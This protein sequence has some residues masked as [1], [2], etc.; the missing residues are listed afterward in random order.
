MSLNSTKM[1][2][3]AAL[4]MA[5]LTLTATAQITYPFNPDENADAYIGAQDLMQFLVVFGLEWEQ[6]EL[7]VDSIP[8]SMYLSSL[9][10]MIEA[11]ALPEGTMPGQFL[12]WTGE[13]WEL[14][15]PKVGCTLPE[16]CNYD[17][18]A[19]V[20]LESMCVLP[21]ACGV[22]GGPG[23]VYDCG[24]ADIP[25]GECDCD[26]N[27]VDALGI[28]GGTCEADEDGDGICDDGDSCVGQADECGV[29]N[30]PGAIYDCGCT[31][32]VEGTCDCDGNVEDVL[33]VCGGS[34]TADEDFDGICDGVDDCVGAYDGCGVCNGPGP[35]LGCGCSDIPEGFCDCNGNVLDAVGTCGGAC[36]ND[37]NGDGICDDGSIPGCTY[38]VACNYDPSASINDG[39]CDF[40]LCY[41]CTDIAACNYNP[42]ATIDNGICWYAEA[43]YDCD[44]NCLIDTDGDGVCDDLEVLGCTDEEACNFEAGATELD[45]SCQYL[46]ECGECGGTGTPGCTDPGACNY[47]ADAACD[48]G[49]C[50][51]EALLDCID[52]EACNFNPDA[53]CSDGSC[54]YPGCNNPLASNY[55][56]TAGCDDGSCI[57]YGCTVDLACN[58]EPTANVDDNS[59]EFGTCPG[60]NNPND[61]GYNPTS[62]NDSLCGAFTYFTNCGA[63]GRF[64]PT[65]LQCDAEYG[66]GLVVSNGGIQQWTVTQ[67]GVYRIEAL[68][69]AGGTHVW[70][71][72]AGGQGALMSG[73]FSL[74]EG[75]ELNFIVGQKGGN[76]IGVQDNEAP[77]G[78]G[79]SFVWAG[80][81]ELLIAAGGGG[82]GSRNDY[83]LASANSTTSGNPAQ[84]QFDAAVNGAGGL[85]NCSGSDYYA[86]G[87]AG[88]LTNGTG[89]G[90]CTDNEANGS[91]FGAGGGLRPLEGGTGGV[92]YQDSQDEGG[93]GGFGGGGG[94]GSDNMGTG[95]GGGYSG[96][97]GGNSSPNNGGGGGGG[98]YNA[99]TSQVNESGVNEG[100]GGVTITLISAQ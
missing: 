67:S 22:C 58:Y 38:E 52:P 93:D 59:C 97:G 20:L 83:T 77:G 8:L 75:Q 81:S 85:N 27:V 28:C 36:Q 71:G 6:E 11:S 56:V 84:N 13:S 33:G 34:C 10:A 87:G 43:S 49:S 69:A 37:L 92:R 76:S 55:N 41:G 51:D 63:E 98:S 3:L 74:E 12:Q 72:V 95:G 68:G 48:D 65:Q 53:V 66:P 61:F 79:G 5:L 7:Q 2:H 86:G 50:V 4:F 45:D 17:E 15:M 39:S 40:T 60:C 21:D 54:V 35:V 19:H 18:T 9:E 73:T 96:G 80:D 90:N 82:G 16:A 26:G 62:T 70:A 29:C 64:G 94:G 78:G 46:D 44:L 100:H 57:V 25:E 89:G 1:K 91:V 99:G 32:P 31:E 24:C 23:A 14:V 88:W 30:G 47:D 42:S